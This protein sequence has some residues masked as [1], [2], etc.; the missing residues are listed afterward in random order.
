MRCCEE[1]R[2]AMP[3]SGK[4]P[5]EIEQARAHARTCGECELLLE[6]YEAD[7]RA[8]STLR[9]APREMPPIMD[10]FADAVMQGI[11]VEP[12]AASKQGEVLR[13]DF[14][15]SWM[16]AAAV[17]LVALGLAFVLG[18]SD[19]QPPSDQPVANTTT[20]EPVATTDP[21]P[22]VADGRDVIV[23]RPLGEEAAPL[24]APRR[25]ERRAPAP[26]RRMRSANRSIVPVGGNTGGDLPM[27]L[28][29]MLR[30]V[31]RAFP[32][33]SP[34]GFDRRVPRLRPGERE[35]RF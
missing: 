34:N 21:Q 17:F 2:R 26:R 31:Q 18:T 6:A 9:K 32:N 22:V 16:A 20:P 3:L 4:T 23:D 30:D 14:G 33:W 5:A 19:Q 15:S 13:P 12:V 8:L 35:V 24:P 11:A 10:G 25:V 1:F 7:E 27:P 28:R 29:N